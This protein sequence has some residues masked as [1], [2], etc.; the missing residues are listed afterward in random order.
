MKA[1][2]GVI[3]NCNRE[4]PFQTMTIES[5]NCRILKEVKVKV[6]LSKGKGNR[7]D[8]SCLLVVSYVRYVD[9]YSALDDKHLVLQCYDTV[10]WVM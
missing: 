9:L 7:H 1:S 4:R 8:A 5:H 3:R 6:T 2:L 10:G